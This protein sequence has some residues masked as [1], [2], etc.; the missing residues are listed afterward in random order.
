MSEDPVSGQS[1][2]S[3][4]TRNITIQKQAEAAAAADLTDTML[5]RDLSARLV[6]EE[7]IQV[8]YDEIMKTAIQLTHADAGTVQILDDKRKEL[9]LLAS[10]GM[11]AM[12]T[13]RFQRV[14]I[15]G[16]T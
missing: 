10:S 15:S 1:R 6:S 16:S 11:P 14:A 7:N 5:L 2:L 3:G 12:M 8:L 13:S 4:I 9:I